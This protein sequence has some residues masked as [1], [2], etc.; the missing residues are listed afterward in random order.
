MRVLQEK[1]PA[2]IFDCM[3]SFRAP[4]AIFKIS[5][6]VFVIPVNLMRSCEIIWDVESAWAA[7]SDEGGRAG[8]MLETNV[9]PAI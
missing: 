3:L 2:R 5:P 6:H 4:S 7:I 9:N 1:A 8:L